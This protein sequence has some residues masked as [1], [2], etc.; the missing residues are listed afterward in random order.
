MGGRAFDKFQ[1]GQE[2]I[3]THGTAVAA[4]RMLMCA[5][6][7]LKPDRTPKFFDR[8]MG[9][10]AKNYDSFIGQYLYQ[11]T[12][13]FPDSY[14]QMLP[15]IFSCG[16]KGGI[17]PSQQTTGA[18]D[19][20]WTHTP[21]L[22]GDNTPDSI[23]LELG[24]DQQAYEAEYLM[25]DRIKISGQVAQGMEVSP[26]DIEAGFFARQQTKTSFTTLS[27]PTVE[28]INAKL[29]RFYLD[30][31]WAGVGGTEKV[32]FLRAFDIEILTGLHPQ[33]HGGANK[34]FDVHGQ[35]YVD[36]M[37]S[38][39]FENDAVADAI[40]DAALAQSLAVVQVKI[41]GAAIGTGA[42]HSLTIAIGGRW[43]E[44]VPMASEDR[45]A[46]LFT[47]TLQGMYDPT[48]AKLLTVAV[49][50]NVSTI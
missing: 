47:A 39:T 5:P 25:F 41:A 32:G 20:L 31:A 33:F 48:G 12:L 8:P 17:T 34:Y 23:T 18:G 4:T 28:P 50:T 15:L 35:G 40:R 10:R 26:V 21:S 22:S 11:D 43:K 27:L 44:P 29:A 6:M 24:D 14:Y 37:A 3:S 36:A 13:K 38:F 2:T 7:S 45:A 9:L 16:L 49:S 30:T 46:N 1:F 19:Y 42:S